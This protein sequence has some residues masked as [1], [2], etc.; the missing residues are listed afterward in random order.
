MKANKV[1]ETLDISRKTLY[2]YV[3]SGKIR[4]KRLENGFMD[5]DESDVRKLENVGIVHENRI[6]FFIGKNRFEYSFDDEK[7]ENIRRF[8]ETL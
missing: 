4:A 2:N 7:I 6:V 1:L 5:Y 8:V 3:K